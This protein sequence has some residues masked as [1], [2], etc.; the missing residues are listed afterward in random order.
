MKRNLGEAKSSALQALLAA[1]KWAPLPAPG[2]SVAAFID[3]GL[4]DENELAV[5]LADSEQN[6]A[7]QLLDPVERRH[8]ILRRCFQRVFLKTVLNWKDALPNLRIEHR[9]DTQPCCLDAPLYGLSF[10]SSGQTALAC[11]SSTNHVGIDVER[12]RTIENVSQLA[13]RFF[14]ADEAG[15]ISKYAADEQSLQF[16]HHWTA[17]EAGLKAIGKGII[18]GL[19]SFVVAHN[20]TSYNIEMTHDSTASDPWSLQYLEFLPAHIVAIVHKPK[21]SSRVSL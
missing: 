14:T 3:D 7:D 2:L 21:N 1:T 6:K 11:A 19:N 4:C 8:F 9:I 13:H 12:I 15:S 18:D 17:K 5:F 16:L 20:S 10:S